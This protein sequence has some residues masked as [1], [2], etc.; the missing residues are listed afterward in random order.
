ME[1]GGIETFYL[2]D[3]ILI[4]KP[5]LMIFRFFLA[6]IEKVSGQNSLIRG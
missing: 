1:M 6:D 5:V 4:N 3:K 2:L